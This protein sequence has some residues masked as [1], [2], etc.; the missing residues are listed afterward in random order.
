PGVECTG[1]VENAIDHLAEARV[2]V[3]PILSGSGTRLKI[4]EAWA[5]GTAVVATSLGAEGLP[6]RHG[7]NILLADDPESF[8]GAVLGLLGSTQDRAR[9]GRAGRDEY[10][11]GFTWNS[12]WAALDSELGP[13]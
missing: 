1:P 11:R 3:A 2:A 10:E 4:V 13:F 8:T 12:A 7:D 9:I 6:A 5:A